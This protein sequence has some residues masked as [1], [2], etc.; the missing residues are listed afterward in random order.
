MDLIVHSHSR[1]LHI[2]R[3][4]VVIGVIYQMMGCEFKFREVEDV[5]FKKSWK[6]KVLVNIGLVGLEIFP[7]RLLFSHDFILW[8]KWEFLEHLGIIMYGVY[9]AGLFTQ[10][11][12]MGKGSTSEGI[13]YT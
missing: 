2:F 7:G 9:L 5:Y 4:A 10:F 3:Y 6:K 1:I 8:T 12:K 13:E 11:E